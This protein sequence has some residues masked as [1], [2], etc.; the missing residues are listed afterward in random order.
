MARIYSRRRGKHGSKKPP[1][2]AAPR[3]IKHKKKEVD[4]LV[5]ELAKKRHSSTLIG[6][7][8]RDQHGIPSV[9]AVT[10]KA[11]S[12]IMKENKMYPE[13]PEDLMSLLKRA[14]ELRKH[15]GA[16]KKDRHSR[17]G[18]ENME[19][20]IRRLGKYYSRKGVIAKGWKY[21]HEEA[22]LIIQK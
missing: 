8:L 2:K 6:T 14:V 5:V 3:W 17:K 22:K 7:I 1:I 16:N 19:S 15:L 12:Q 10:G 11:I 18:L 9:K 13:M 21:S 4:D 20:K